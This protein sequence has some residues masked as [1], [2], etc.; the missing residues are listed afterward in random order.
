MPNLDA[1]T[2]N[3][4]TG[5]VAPLLAAL[6]SAG[7][8]GLAALWAT[9]WEA[10]RADRRAGQEALLRKRRQTIESTH[11]ALVEWLYASANT[12]VPVG[13][14]RLHP[15]PRTFEWTVMT[16]EV[17]AEMTRFTSDLV[18]RPA[19]S[20]LSD[21]DQKALVEVE[22]RLSAATQGQ[23]ERVESGL[24]PEHFRASDE[25]REAVQKSIDS[26]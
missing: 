22:S 19:G 9:R 14:D 15:N 5:V 25:L 11:D 21:E 17:L 4:L 6:V 16:P 20:G 23:L 18:K 12:L 13:Q 24:E 2:M 3:W 10:N 26:F 8:A 7:V 1:N